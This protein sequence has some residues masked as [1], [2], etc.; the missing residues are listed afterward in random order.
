MYEKIST[1]V[2]KRILQTFTQELLYNHIEI[3]G[4]RFTGFL[5]LY[6]FFLSI[7]IAANAF[8]FLELHPLIVFVVSF[9]GLIFLAYALMKMSSDSKGRFVENI[10]PDALQIVASNMKSGMTTE[11]ALFVAG[12]PEFGLLETELKNAS[13][14]ISSGE[15][16]E[17]A[18]HGIGERIDSISLKKTLW[19]ISQGV[20]S[21]GQMADLL[22]Q[23]SDDLKNQNAI[24]DQIRADI[25]IYIL[26]I[27]F[28]AAFGAPLLFGVSSFIVEV[29]SAQLANTPTINVS[30]LPTSSN[31]GAIRGFASGASDAVS[32][33]FII[34]FSMIALAFTVLFSS[35]TIGVINNGKEIDGLRYLI[36][37]A[38]VSFLVFF[39]MRAIMATFFGSLL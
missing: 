36:P 29:L 5:F 39:A 12:R 14:R 16:V 27:F 10:L 34:G 15:K 20:R 30:Q 2:P 11:R 6:S 26:L 28:T 35:L 24:R 3:D 22:F 23:L 17:T 19:L 18:L 38:V 4:E 37:L 13:K 7:G 1:L 21:G 33:G 25:S 32:S 9:A 8:I 31:F